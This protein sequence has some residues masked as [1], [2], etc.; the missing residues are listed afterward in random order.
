MSTLSVTNISTKEIDHTNGTTAI[1]MDQ[2]SVIS[3]SPIPRFVS[4][5]FVYAVR[6]TSVAWENVGVTPVGYSY[7]QISMNVGNYYNTTS[8]V[9]TCPLAG[10]YL[11]CPSALVGSGGFYSTFYIYKNNINVAY[12]GIHTNTNGISQWKC[13]SQTFAIDC[14]ANDQL[15]I[16][17]A[18]NGA[19]IYGALYNFLTIW[20]HG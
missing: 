16:R 15:Q 8:A 14:A 2:S 1:I 6:N 4:Q 19:T 18:S 11:V 3:E 20:Y 9:F 13:G 12:N 10:V 17:A 7:N 5:P